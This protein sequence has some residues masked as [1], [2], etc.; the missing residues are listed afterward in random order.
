MRRGIVMEGS[1]ATLRGQDDG[2]V[3]AMLRQEIVTRAEVLQFLAA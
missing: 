1:P 2:V 3:R